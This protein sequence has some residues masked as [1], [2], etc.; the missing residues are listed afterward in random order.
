MAEELKC[1]VRKFRRKTALL[2]RKRKHPQRR[3]LQ[4]NGIPHD[5]AVGMDSIVYL[6]WLF[7]RA[8]QGEQVELTHQAKS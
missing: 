1:C 8:Q 6:H 5:G 3:A 7:N 2:L 4:V